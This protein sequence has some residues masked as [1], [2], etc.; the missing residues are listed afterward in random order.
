[1]YESPIM[2]YQSPVEEII[3]KL[4]SEENRKQEELILDKCYKIGVD[5]NKEE[6]LKA[7]TY[8]RQ[9]YQKGYADGINEVIL[10]LEAEIESSDKYIREYEDTEE[11]GC[12]NQGLRAALKAV[13][14]MER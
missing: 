9:Q 10:Q 7:L 6:L 4:I 5:V 8:D 3:Q 11:Q 12:F 2:I 13:R 1:M 14:K